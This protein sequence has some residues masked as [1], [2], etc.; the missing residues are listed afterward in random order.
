MSSTATNQAGKTTSTAAAA[1]A[2]G[3]A[4]QDKQGALP[5]LGAFEEDDEFEEFATEDWTDEA[6]HT[7]N[8]QQW[9]V[10]WDDDD[11]EDDFANQL[12]TEL[13]KAAA[14]TATAAVPSASAT[15]A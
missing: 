6:L 1:P 11:I 8:Q 7:E 9:V 15:P 5:S 12:R 2:T 10:N 3:A 13:S 4:A 14:A